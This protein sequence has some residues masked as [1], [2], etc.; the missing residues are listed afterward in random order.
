MFKIEYTL[1]VAR[2]VMVMLWTHARYG[3]TRLTYFVL[4]QGQ[5]HQIRR[6]FE[7]WLGRS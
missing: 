1:Y 3:P 4:T 7:T 6:S 5:G 2:D